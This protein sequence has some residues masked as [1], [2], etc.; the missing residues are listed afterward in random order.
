MANQTATLNAS[1][2]DYG[3][4][5][6]LLG[7]FDSTYVYPFPAAHPR[8]EDKFSTTLEQSL[9]F[10]MRANPE[11]IHDAVL[12]SSQSAIAAGHPR[13]PVVAFFLE[14]QRR[15]AGI[16]QPQSV[17][18]AGLCPNPWWQVAVG[19]PEVTGR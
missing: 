19:G 3:R 6:C 1:A 16:L 17:S 9:V 12:D 14:T 11:P 2:S 5:A 15:M 7:A 13:R 18:L 10:V 4:Q 8:W